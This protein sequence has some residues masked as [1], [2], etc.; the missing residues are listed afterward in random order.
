ML[1]SR[2]IPHPIVIRSTQSLSCTLVFDGLLLDHIMTS[3][4]LSITL[5]PIMTDGKWDWKQFGI[6]PPY[7]GMPTDVFVCHTEGEEP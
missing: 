3:M 7:K 5:G 4:I 1:S 6:G 2:I